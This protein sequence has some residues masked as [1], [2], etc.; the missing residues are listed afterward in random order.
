MSDT[1]VWAKDL[2]SY[3]VK[4]DETTGDKLV[5]PDANKIYRFILDP[6]FFQCQ[7]LKRFEYDKYSLL[8]PNLNIYT[9]SDD[10]HLNIIV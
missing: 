4:V 9:I 7:D 5:N 2:N 8:C 1:A 6:I 10:E 3:A